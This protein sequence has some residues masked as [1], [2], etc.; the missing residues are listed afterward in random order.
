MKATPPCNT[1]VNV[2]YSTNN[3]IT[4]YLFTF[5][6]SSAAKDETFE[7]RLSLCWGVVVILGDNNTLR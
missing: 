3:R 2:C 1:V 6:R 5:K 7:S 4:Q